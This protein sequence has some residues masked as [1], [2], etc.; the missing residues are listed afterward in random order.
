M[1]DLL[2]ERLLFLA[3][4]PTCAA[5]L[6]CSWRFAVV[7]RRAKERLQQ[8]LVTE[9]AGRRP[10]GSTKKVKFAHAW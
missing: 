7:G 10:R 3:D 1:D 5:L 4:A 2:P 8:G 9:A 6:R